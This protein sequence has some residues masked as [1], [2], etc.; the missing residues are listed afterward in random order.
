[1]EAGVCPRPCALL[2][3]ST[4]RTDC[5]KRVRH[6]RLY[7]VSAC[8]C[9]VCEHAQADNIRATMSIQTLSHQVIQDPINRSQVD[10]MDQYTL[11]QVLGIWALVSLPMALLSWVL[12]PAIIPSSPLHR[13]FHLAS[14]PGQLQRG[15]YDSGVLRSSKSKP[16][17]LRRLTRP[18]RRMRPRCWRG[19]AVGSMDAGEPG[20]SLTPWFEHEQLRCRV[21]GKRQGAV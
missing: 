14:A 7:I 9:S 6:S 12:A 18:S 1:M 20:S 16:L 19:G 15:D 17:Q 5:E 8:Y 2:L 4:P 11:W 10:H 3:S 21:A 13:S